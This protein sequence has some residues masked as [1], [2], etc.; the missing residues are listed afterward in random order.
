MEGA[1]PVWYIAAVIVVLGNLIRMV[2]N[3]TIYDH[4]YHGVFRSVVTL[5]T[6]IV[7]LICFGLV[8]FLVAA[9]WAFISP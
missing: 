3:T 8:A 2:F 5:F 6:G 9:K 1:K 4:Q 7:A